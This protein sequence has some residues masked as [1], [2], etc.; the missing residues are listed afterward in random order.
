MGYVPFGAGATIRRAA[1]SRAAVSATAP[2]NDSKIPA[3][4]ADCTAQ[5]WLLSDFSSQI[6]KEA[7]APNSSVS[8]TEPAISV[9][10][11]SPGAHPL[12]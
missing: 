2:A 4:G 10:F 11:T 9:Q 3:G 6:A 7:P 12:M 1:C 8:Q 5:A